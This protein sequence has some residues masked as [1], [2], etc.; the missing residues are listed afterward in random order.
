MLLGA[1]NYKKIGLIG[2]LPVGL[3]G[4][5]YGQPFKVLVQYDVFGGVKAQ[6]YEDEEGGGIITEITGRKGEIQGKADAFADWA[7]S[8]AIS[9][10]K[11]TSGGQAVILKYDRFAKGNKLTEEKIDIQKLKTDI[12]KRAKLFV[13]D[14]HNEVVKYNKGEGKTK[15]ATEKVNIGPSKPAV[16]KAP[17]KKDI[18]KKYKTIYVG[19]YTVP[20]Y[21]VPKH[22]RRILLK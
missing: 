11:V 16:K 12:N 4:K 19:P 9:Q 5:L 3:K 21:T 17:T 7:I 20:G 2:A 15:K 13:T 22:K 10:G 14:L 1:Y 6:L 8:R 18:V